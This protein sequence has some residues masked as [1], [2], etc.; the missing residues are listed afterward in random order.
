MSFLLDNKKNELNKTNN[1][2]NI[3]CII[4]EMDLTKLLKTQLL[5]KYEELGIKKYTSKKN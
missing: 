3:T 5:E 2:I 4:E 1:S